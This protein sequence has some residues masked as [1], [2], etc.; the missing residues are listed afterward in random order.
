MLCKR[1]T[2]GEKQEREQIPIKIK[3]KKEEQVVWNR[4]WRQ[5]TENYATV[6]KVRHEN[7]YTEL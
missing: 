6:V 4:K 2:E 3:R 1:R 7:V 5:K